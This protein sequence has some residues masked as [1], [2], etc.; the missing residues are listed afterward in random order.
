MPELDKAMKEID[1]WLDDKKK[2]L[3]LFSERTERY[4]YSDTNT[5]VIQQL[6]G[7]EFLTGLPIKGYGNFAD[8]AYKDYMDKI[9][10][11]ISDVTPEKDFQTIIRELEKIP[12]ACIVRD[13]GSRPKEFLYSLTNEQKETLEWIKD[14]TTSLQSINDQLLDKALDITGETDLGFTADWLYDNARTY[15]S[16]D[17]L[18]AQINGNPRYLRINE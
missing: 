1:M 4:Y 16:V 7:T 17:D 14:V 8:E 13:N 15:D 12:P 18:E 5:F 3:K 10:Q 11:A 2:L 9:D 6:K